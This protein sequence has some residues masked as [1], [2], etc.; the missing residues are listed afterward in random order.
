MLQDILFIALCTLLSNGEDFADME[1]FGNQREDWLK[2]FLELPQGIPTHDTFNRVLQA[3]DPDCLSKILEQDAQFLID[4][5]KDKIVSFDGK[6]MRGVSPHSRGNKG[7][8]ILSA[9]VGEHRLC[10]GQ[11]KVEDKSNEITAIPNLIDSLDL[12]GSIVSIDAI[13]CQTE[14]AKKIV[15]AKADYLLAVKKNQGSLY[16]QVADEFTWKD[17]LQFSE[18]WEYDHGRYETRKCSIVSANEVLSPDLLDKWTGIKTVV[19]IEATRTIN[20]VSSSQARFYISSQQQEAEFYNRAARG[21]WSIENQLHWHLDITFKEDANRSR[22]GNAPQNLN[23]LRKIALHRVAGMTEKLSLQ[24]RRF[25]AS[26]NLNYLE[27]ILAV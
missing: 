23:I 1:E 18:D 15:Q 2:K 20:N 21:H 19:K 6:K 25:R 26:L 5:V 9:W 7:L 13:G 14:V 4:G 12:T 10:L 3:I 27:K 17:V 24:K 16:D 8:Y 22:S 11:S